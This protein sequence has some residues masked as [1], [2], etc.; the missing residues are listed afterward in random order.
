MTTIASPSQSRFLTVAEAAEALHV[1][2]R[3]IRE[4]IAEGDLDAVRG[5]GAHIVRIRRTHVEA[6][7]QPVLLPH[8]SLP[9][10]K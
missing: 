3:F 10:R 1:T 6:L 9:Q 2:E 7:L 4:L 5:V 8:E